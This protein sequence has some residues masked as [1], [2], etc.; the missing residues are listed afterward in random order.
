MQQMQ[1]PTTFSLDYLLDHTQALYDEAEWGF[2]KGRL[3]IN[4]S[5]A[6]C[7]VRE[8]AE[9]TG[10]PADVLEPFPLDSAATSSDM[11]E[12]VFTGCNNIRYKHVYF[13]ARL[14]AEGTGSEPE[15]ASCEAH[16]VTD[17]NQAREISRVAWFSF[18]EGLNRI[19]AH[20]VERR[21]LFA[22]LHQSITASI[23]RE[24]T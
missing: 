1:S 4:E 17:K 7:A 12:E 22:Q 10:L 2:P 15:F 18:E 19:R 21:T 6:C 24:M 5:D 20:N 11:L 8:F 16:D 13:V 9:E 14:K 23:P 3:N